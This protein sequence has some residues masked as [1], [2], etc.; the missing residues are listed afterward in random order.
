MLAR[1]VFISALFGATATVAQVPAAGPAAPTAQDIERASALADRL[2]AEGDAAGIFVNTTDSDVARVT[3]VASGMN[4]L[5]G[6]IE[7]GRIHIFDSAAA[8]LPRGDDVSCVSRTMDI[9]LTLYATRYSPLP[10]EQLIMADA[11]NAI[12]QRWP[13]ATPFEGDLLSMSVEGRDP[14]LMAAFNI[15]TDEGPRLTIALISHVGE[16]G[17]KARATGPA[18]D[19]MM[20]ALVANM[21]F[22]SALLDPGEP[23]IE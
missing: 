17:Y 12:R 10:S 14:P 23:P 11:V 13:E 5:F 4:C 16:W 21:T 20:L 2:I 18:E 7:V 8:G 15:E 6:D 9:D 1:L 3:H 22:M 19:P